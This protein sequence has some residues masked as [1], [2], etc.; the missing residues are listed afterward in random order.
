MQFVKTIGDAVMLVSADPV[1]LLT[2]VLDLEE[3]VEETAPPSRACGP[4][5]RSGLP[6]A[7]RATGSAVR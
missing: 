7:A 2:T 1:K 5:S 4:V 3:A 6:S